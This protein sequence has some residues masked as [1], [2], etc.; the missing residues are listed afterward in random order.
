VRAGRAHAPWNQKIFI[1]G[2][3]CRVRAKPLKFKDKYQQ[4][5]LAGG[6]MK[7][8]AACPSVLD[9]IVHV[10]VK[11][12]PLLI[13]V[14][15][16]ICGAFGGLYLT[17]LGLP[18]HFHA[19]STGQNTFGR[20]L[21][22]QG[23]ATSLFYLLW[24]LLLLTERDVAELAITRPF[25]FIVCV[26]NP[27]G[28][29]SSIPSLISFQLYTAPGE[30][31]SSGEQFFYQ[32]CGLVLFVT[33]SSLMTALVLLLHKAIG[34]AASLSGKW[35]LLPFSV[36]LVF[37]MWWY[38]K[39]PQ[40]ETEDGLL[41]VTLFLPMALLISFSILIYTFFAPLSPIWTF[42]GAAPFVVWVY[43][44]FPSPTLAG[45]I[46]T[47]VAYAIIIYCIIS[48]VD[49]ERRYLVIAVII[50]L[51]VYANKNIFKYQFPGLDYSKNAVI[52]HSEYLR[53]RETNR[54]RAQAIVDYVNPVRA[55]E[56]WA[57]KSAG[58]VAKKPKLVVVA[59][60]GG[61]YRAT[62]WTAT[63]L[64]A[65]KDLKANDSAEAAFPGFSG[66]VRLLTGASG[67]MVA[68]AYLA[69]PKK[70]VPHTKEAP[71][72]WEKKCSQ[73]AQ[74]DSLSLSIE[75]DIDLANYEYPPWDRG[76]PRDSLTGVARQGILLD[77]PGS[78]F[79]HFTWEK[80]HDRGYVLEEH[81]KKLNVSFKEIADEERIGNL[82][83]IILS[84][85]VVGN[86]KPLFISNLDFDILDRSRR[87][88]SLK[89]LTYKTKRIRQN[90]IVFFD[91]FPEAWA[92]GFKLKTAVR[93]NASFPVISPAV[94]LPAKP[95]QRVVDAGYYDNYG[96]NS[97]LIYLSAPDIKNWI[98]KNTSG[99]VVVQIRA[100][101]LD[102]RS[103]TDETANGR[104]AAG[105]NASGPAEENGNDWKGQEEC[106]PK[107]QPRDSGLR[108]A[109]EGSVGVISS[110]I[111][112]VLA[113][114]QSSMVLR[115]DNELSV[116]KELYNVEY[117]KVCGS[118]AAGMEEVCAK[119]KSEDF[120][121]TVIFEYDG[122]ANLTWGLKQY[123]L[124]CMKK[125]FHGAKQNKKALDRLKELWA[126]ALN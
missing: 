9:S 91:W 15:L 123:E 112:G 21:F 63:V 41:L 32:I 6:T 24:A 85:V 18:D 3:Y 16:L 115:N 117:E 78:L 46:F 12:L 86:G 50:A 102:D 4:Y 57:S 37:A 19:L 44:G 93:M 58:A 10:L 5:I 62:F 116:L 14:Q 53:G 109:L 79:A 23:Y 121:E 42:L 39:L 113:A 110:P 98:V 81:W 124:D 17:S 120:F 29:I 105:E 89:I 40:P 69:A 43:N 30:P 68:A 94:S 101:P 64:D 2:L 75:C 65:L 119:V 34:Q 83:S 80:A 74:A 22:A 76:L 90:G 77:I 97:A 35:I 103:P 125:R 92:E 28:L 54:I 1:G 49:V 71:E 114:R 36:L 100:F 56:A 20:T 96:V 38:A 33:I 45:A 95:L 61:A 111:E 70:P 13:A 73:A 66:N 27:L 107:E 104:A 8:A 87:K 47:P 11:H 99:A 55:L 48:A 25:W 84:P 88:S 126:E 51:F 118:H 122:I 52:E 7:D 82:P 59:A 108:Q 106:K 26:L 31:A 67:G 72:S 60:S